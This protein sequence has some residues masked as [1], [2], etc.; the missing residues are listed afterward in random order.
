MKKIFTLFTFVFLTSA[1]LV[2]QCPTDATP[3][4]TN[5]TF[6]L[7]YATEA[8]R[9]VAWEALESI[10]FP[11]GDGC[12]CAETI[13]L[14]KAE[15][16]TDGPVG[17][18]DVYRIR[19]VTTTNDFFGGVNGAFEGMLTFNNTDGTSLVC[20]YDIMVN[21]SN[22]NGIN[23]IEIFP[24]PV[25]DQLT[26]VNGKGAATIYNVLGQPL[27]RIIINSNHTTI[28]LPNLLNGQYFLQVIQEDG[29][30]LIKQFSKTY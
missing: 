8:D 27:Q 19:A 4:P 23:P 18:D 10:T 12:M 16:T 24:N 13:T 28:Q 25:K 15:L 9:D 22:I 2:A 30:M 21:S 29:T 5:R 3:N 6:N 14:A 7:S 11:A 1:M 26:V 20:E 17:D